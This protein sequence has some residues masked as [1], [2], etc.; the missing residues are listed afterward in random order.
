MEYIKDYDFDLTYHLSKANV[1]VDAL[2]RRSYVASLIASKKWRFMVDIA[3]A[4]YR[5]L[6]QQGVAL[7]TSLSVMSRVYHSVIT[8]QREDQHIQRI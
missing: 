1:V 3:K 2:S 4:V 5:I 7:V 8:A 6:R